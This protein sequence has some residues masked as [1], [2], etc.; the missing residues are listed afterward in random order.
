MPTLNRYSR[1]SEKEGF[2]VRANV[3]GETP[4]T[5][6]V[7]PLASRIFRIVGYEDGDG[8]PSNLVWAMYDLDMV[9]T[10]SSIDVDATPDAVDPSAVLRDLEIESELTESERARL[11]SYLEA[12]SGVDAE[13]VATLRE[14]LLEDVSESALDD[15]PSVRG[16]REQPVDDL[17][18]TAEDIALTLNVWTPPDR[19]ERA[20]RALLLHEDFV[21][22]SVRTFASH[23]RLA[24]EPVVAIGEQRI[25]YEIESSSS[26]SRVTVADAR[27]H[28]RTVL[29]GSGESQYDYQIRRTYPDGTREIGYVSGEYLVKYD[30][31]GERG[32]ATLLKY[33]LDDVLPPDREYFGD[34]DDEPYTAEWLTDEYLSLSTEEVRRRMEERGSPAPPRDLPNEAEPDGGNEEVVDAIG[35]MPETTV[36]EV[37]RVSNSGNLVSEWNDGSMLVVTGSIDADA[38]DLIVV[39]VPGGLTTDTQVERAVRLDAVP[40]EDTSRWL[41]SR[42]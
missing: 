26:V 33:D 27:G 22:W 1:D 11:V 29:T 4:I 34:T 5:L 7:T 23:R 42:L 28:R 21:K 2:Y 17:P 32:S 37:D 41:H 3:G 9:Y 10:L 19:T 18:E 40:A 36:V 25:V 14:R 6:Q 8:V 12:Y 16:G 31:N 35:S 15:A 20:R 39:R 30:S 13:R 38:G 24:D